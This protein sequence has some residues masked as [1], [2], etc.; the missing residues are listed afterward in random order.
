[1]PHADTSIATLVSS[2]EF[3][4]K[5]KN[6]KTLSDVTNFAKELIAPT[7]QKMLEA[8]LDNHL[9]YQKYDVVGRGS[10]NSRNGHSVK[11][12]KTSFGAADL[13]VPRDRNST[14]NPLAVKKYETVENDV[15][16][17]VISMYAKG[18]TTRDISAHM[19]D[20]YGID[21]SATMISTITDKVLPLVAEW[22]SRPLTA[23]Y[24][25]VSLDGV[26]FKVRDSGRIVNRT[27][28]IVLGTNLEGCKE[29]LG[30]WVGETEGAKFW[31]QVLTELKNRGVED[32]LIASIDGLSGF[33]EAI[34]AVYP[35]TEIQQCVVHQL[36]NTLKNVP[37]K[38]KKEFAASLRSIYTAP[39]EGAG[40]VA[41]D[42][43]KREWPQYALYL[44]SWE[45]KWTELSAF[46]KYPAP[47][48][49]IMYTTN[50]IESLNRQFRKVTKTTSVFPH[51]EALRKLLWLAQ[52]DIAKHWTLPIRNW[53][54]IIGQLAI[55]FP[56]RIKI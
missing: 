48:R 19:H 37:H 12:L 13:A 27:A 8:E 47:I 51:E 43:I 31:M 10:G 50:A 26:F 24:A 35:N 52:R 34:G 6:L 5:A 2:E 41:L 53:G 20:I 1:M 9:G 45:G 25:L 22:Q 3:Q 15:E 42:D 30:I 38:H 55:M 33:S 29:I 39:T 14:F 36:R 16:E 17:K 49:R 28:Y 44:K 23:T 4:E 11:Q 46:F 7:L 54:E 18:M 32:I 21:V 40:I 56:D